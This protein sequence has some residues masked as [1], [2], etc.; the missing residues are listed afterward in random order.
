MSMST[1]RP[2]SAMST[3][4]TNSGQVTKRPAPIRKVRPVSIAVTGVSRDGE[5]ENQLYFRF[6]FKA[7]FHL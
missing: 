7:L 5:L 1:S 2:G 4:T 6:M 3:S